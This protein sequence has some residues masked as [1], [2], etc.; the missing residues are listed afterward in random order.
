MRTQK[1]AWQLRAEEKVANTMSKIPRAWLLPHSDLER[2][3]Q[4]KH[5]SGSFV[6]GF[7]SDGELAII[8]NATVPL[9][10]KIK[11]GRYTAVQ[12]AQAYCKTVAIAHQIV[13]R[14]LCCVPSE[15][16]LGTPCNSDCL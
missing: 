5:L 7:L 1:E 12:V 16:P 10:E 6:E 9:V 11:E 8:R 4:R 3:K 2:A 15:I 14:G 13:G